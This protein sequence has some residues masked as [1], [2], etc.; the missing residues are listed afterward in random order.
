MLN[1][2]LELYIVSAKD[3]SLLKLG[4]IVCMVKKIFSKVLTTELEILM[5]FL[6]NLV[7]VY[8]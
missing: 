8:V 6:I 3:L 7:V 2:C 5:R 4:G 1:G